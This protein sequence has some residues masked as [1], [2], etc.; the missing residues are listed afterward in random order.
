MKP[1]LVCTTL[2]KG[3]RTEPVIDTNNATHVH[4]DCKKKPFA[5]ISSRVAGPEN[6]KD[7]SETP[8]PVEDAKANK[9]NPKKAAG[10]KSVVCAPKIRIE[11]PADEDIGEAALTECNEAT[12]DCEIATEEDYT[13]ETTDLGA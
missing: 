2:P 5:I 1:H 11:D 8:N 12:T 3:L 7:T 10:R 4:T 6:D 9:I 13:D